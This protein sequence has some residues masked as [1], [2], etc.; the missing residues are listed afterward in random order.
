MSLGLTPQMGAADRNFV[1]G[2]PCLPKE[3]PAVVTLDSRGV[4]PLDAVIH[5]RKRKERTI[6][7]AVRSP[8]MRRLLGLRYG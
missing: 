3:S 1:N 4:T 6:V 5:K 7:I 2:A 8:M